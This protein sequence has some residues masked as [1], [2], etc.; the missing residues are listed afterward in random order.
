[1]SDYSKPGSPGSS[2][3]TYT[4][5][6]IT[7]WLKAFLAKVFG[8]LKSRKFWALVAAVV[9]IG[10][11]VGLG[12]ITQWQALQA[13]IAALAAYSTGVAVEGGLLALANSRR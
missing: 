9:A 13:L 10:Q 6:P 4:P 11:A 7:E 1:M 3:P 8:E 12:E 2:S 5:N